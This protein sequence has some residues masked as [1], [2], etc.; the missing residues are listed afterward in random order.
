MA[1]FGFLSRLTFLQDAASVVISK[2]N[3]S[4]I[5]N[6]EK[7][8]AIKKVLYL[9]AIE[10]I[11]GDYLEFGMFTGS[12]FCHAIRCCR[13]MMYLSPSIYNTSFFGFD[14]FSGFGELDEMDRHPFFKGENFKTSFEKAQI[15]IDR[16]IKG[17]FKFKIIPGYF[18]NTLSV[19]PDSYG[20][21]KAR[22]IFIDSDT[23]A[24]SSKA[25]E[26][27]RPII[28]E[29]TFL[30]LDDFFAYHGRHDRGVAKAFSEFISL[31]G[32]QARQVFTYG[33]GGAVFIISAQY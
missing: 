26:F 5:H 17:D 33:M 4:V 7:Y 11:D 22:A 28:Q 29:G 15:R 8:I 10:E 27:C 24:S 23:Y 12:S 19:P 9:S 21:K 2:I 3:S 18:E 13:S 14:S 20:I 16:V 32:N 6:V 1:N 31:S 30:I 25:F